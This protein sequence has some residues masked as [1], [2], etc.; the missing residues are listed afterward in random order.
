[1]IKGANE[2]KVGDIIRKGNEVITVHKIIKNPY[3]GWM[4]FYYGPYPH[5]FYGWFNPW[6]EIFVESKDNIL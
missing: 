1:M 3:K 2:I 6:D 4:G 5:Q